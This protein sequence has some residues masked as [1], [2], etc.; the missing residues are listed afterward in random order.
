[1]FY[2]VSTPHDV[3][4]NNEICVPS[5]SSSMLSYYIFIVNYYVSMYYTN[6]IYIIIYIVLS[7]KTKPAFREPLYLNT[8]YDIYICMYVQ[9]YAKV[10]EQYTYWLFITYTFVIYYS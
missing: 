1:M 3:Y 9:M 2:I 7:I 8:I 6:Y 5:S 4:V 10:G